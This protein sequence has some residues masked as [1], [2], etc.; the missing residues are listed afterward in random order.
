[1]FTMVRY[2]LL[3]TVLSLRDMAQKH[4]PRNP[5]ALFSA[6]QG[7]CDSDFSTDD[8]ESYDE[9]V[10][11][12]DKADEPTFISKSSEK[13]C[14]NTSLP[15]PNFEKVQKPSFLDDKT[16][17]DIDWDKIVRDNTKTE[18]IPDITNT[19]AMPPPKSYE[20]QTDKLKPTIGDNSTPEP[21]STT[22]RNNPNP[23]L[24]MWCTS[25]ALN[26]NIY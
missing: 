24:G 19:N 22:K 16:K 17:R 12:E 7:L 13:E 3:N 20:P 2:F 10:K 1:M 21:P 26:S 5:F 15:A 6:A 18:D 23:S 11:N 25:N 9:T 14:T 4:K 8:E